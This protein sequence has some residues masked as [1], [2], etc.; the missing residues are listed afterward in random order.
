[1]NPYL[2]DAVG[3]LD[4][5]LCSR[6]GPNDPESTWVVTEEIDVRRRLRRTSSA[7]KSLLKS[8]GRTPDPVSAAVR[9]R[10]RQRMLD[11]L[12]VDFEEVRRHFPMH[13]L[14]PDLALVERLS[15]SW[16]ARG[17]IPTQYDGLAQRVSILP[18]RVDALIRELVAEAGAQEFVDAQKNYRRKFTKNHRG[19]LR[20]LAYL[21]GECS[22]MLAIRLDFSY[23][24]P[25]LWPVDTRS[26]VTL[27]EA[28]LHRRKILAWVKKE[29]NLVGYSWR[30]EYGLLKGYHYHVLLLLAGSLHQ[31]DISIAKHIGE[32]WN[33]RITDGKGLHWNCNA[34]TYKTRGLGMLDHRDTPQIRKFLEKV[35]PYL[36]KTEEV[37]EFAPPKG[38]RTF[39]RSITL[40]S[41]GRKRGRPRRPQA[42]LREP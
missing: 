1:M 22:R 18:D 30:L 3:L 4:G 9:E 2:D 14:A 37:V 25:A 23:R 10:D 29:Y 40:T 16:E 7:I 20:N 38:I 34:E 28:V 41:T 39:G 15:A 19:L 6:A 26:P 36:T 5:A 32:H 42:S 17:L 35:V 31:Q 21:S 8:R 24:K 33:V 13:R 27:E 12:R 11:V